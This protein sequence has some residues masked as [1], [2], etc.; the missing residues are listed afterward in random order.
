MKQTVKIGITILV[1][2]TLAMSGVAL[3]Q[4]GEDGGDADDVTRGVEWIMEKLAPLVDAGTISEEAAEEV[5]ETLVNEL[6]PGRHH[7]RVVHGL[8]EAAGFLDIEVGDL[9]ERL[10]G[11]ETLAQIAGDETDEL[12]DY[13]VADVEEH[14]AQAVADGKLTQPEA[15]EK[16]AEAEERIT[17]FVNE[18]PPERPEGEEWGLGERRGGPGF[19]PGPG[20]PPAEDAAASI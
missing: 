5:A 11:G 19:G 9:A 6:R 15:D 16:L 8:R 4:T 10:R 17:T 14:L 18:G 20:G 13:L 1:V 7:R 3:A 12:I 2:A